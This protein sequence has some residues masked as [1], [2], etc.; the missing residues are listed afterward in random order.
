MEQ[1]QRSVDKTAET[2]DCKTLTELFYHTVHTV[3]AKDYTEEQ[4]NVWATKQMDL[5]KMERN[6]YL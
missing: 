2:Q 3:N 6:S 5:E 4:L 1:N